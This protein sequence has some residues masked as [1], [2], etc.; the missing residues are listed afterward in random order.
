M[1]QL[2]LQ[3]I[4]KEHNVTQL[5]LAELTKY[6]QS[7]ISQIERGRVDAPEKFYKKLTEVLGIK[8]FEPYM[9]PE[10]VEIVDSKPQVQPEAQNNEPCSNSSEEQKMASRLLDMID[11]RDQRISELESENKRL[12]ELLLRLYEK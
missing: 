4:R 10:R 12:H 1:R 3:R 8:D 2:D 5:R 9:L 6:P 7:F 11:R